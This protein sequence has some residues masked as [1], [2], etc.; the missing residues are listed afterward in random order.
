MRKLNNAQQ[1]YI[2]N[3]VLKD[4]KDGDNDYYMMD[5]DDLIDELKDE[6]DKLE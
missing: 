3:V 4:L 5:L 2:E 6:L 1:E